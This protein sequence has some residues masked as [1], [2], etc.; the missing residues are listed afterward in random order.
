MIEI[1]GD[2]SMDAGGRLDAKWELF[3][4]S[5]SHKDVEREGVRVTM[6]GGSKDVEDAEGKKT[7]RKQQAIIE[8]ICDKGRT[9]LED[10]E[11]STVLFDAWSRGRK[12][13][14]D[15]DDP[16]DDDEG[17]GDDEKDN[18]D[19]NKDRSLKF[20]GYGPPS[21]GKEMNMDQLRLEWR[22]KYACEGASNGDEES[23]SSA[24]WGFFTWIVIV[25]FMGTAAYLIFGSWLNY[26]RYGA[27]G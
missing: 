3:S 6:N 7:K 16:E 1:A 24:H 25:V 5:S 10:W 14:R 9:G 21:G 18:P 2:Y 20:I 17:G 15:E 23:G 27:R 11:E 26:N 22:T 12:S 4:S 8:F 13:K 19:A